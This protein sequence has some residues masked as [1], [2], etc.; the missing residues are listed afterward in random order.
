MP[1]VVAGAALAAVAALAVT[2]WPA[3]G[4]ESSAG[5]REVP[6]SKSAP[7]TSAPA[8]SAPASSLGSS[9]AEQDYCAIAGDWQGGLTPGPT[10]PDPAALEQWFTTSLGY[11]EQLTAAAPEEVAARWAEY[12]KAYSGLL[13]GLGQSGWDLAATGAQQADPTLTV[14]RDELEA[15]VSSRCGLDP[16]A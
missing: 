2:I 15:D 1:L 7:A 14:L 8:T 4:D 11:V 5:R 6:G 10:A 13:D 9:G 3:H 16:G 12:E